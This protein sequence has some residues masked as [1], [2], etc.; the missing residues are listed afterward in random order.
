MFREYIKIMSIE[1]NDIS[2]NHIKN[3][4]TKGIDFILPK[5]IFYL[6]YF[7]NTYYLNKFLAWKANVFNT[8]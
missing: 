2:I 4:E 6:N 7:E 3:H 1:K 8:L 5:Y